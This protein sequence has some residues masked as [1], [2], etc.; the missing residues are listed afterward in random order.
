MPK[1]AENGIGSPPPQ[2]LDGGFLERTTNRRLDR[3]A[4]VPANEDPR[5]GIVTLTWRILGL[6]SPT[7]GSGRVF[8][9]DADAKAKRVTLRLDAG[10]RLTFSTALT[11]ES[12]AQALKKA[13]TTEIGSLSDEQ[14][15]TALT[16]IWQPS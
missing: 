11:R 2:H 8:A 1:A 5:A 16:D 7:S 12:Q 15:E 6:A 13:N 10:S 4:L 3:Q 9:L 14:L